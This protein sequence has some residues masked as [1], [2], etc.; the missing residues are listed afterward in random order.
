MTV[1]GTLQ[2]DE[3]KYVVKTGLDWEFVCSSWIE[4]VLDAFAD[5]QEVG[6]DEPL[7][8][9]AVPLLLGTQL[10]RNG[11][12]LVKG[13]EKEIGGTRALKLTASI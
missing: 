8:D 12:R 4:P 6:V 9:L 7:D 10:A 5:N 2:K 1:L 11:Y 13:E 3:S